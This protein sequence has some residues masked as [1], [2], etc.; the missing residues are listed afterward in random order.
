MCRIWFKYGSQAK[1][2]SHQ[3]E[4]EIWNEGESGCLGKT[5][6]E[7]LTTGPRVVTEAIKAV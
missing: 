4:S 5:I 3:T 7:K 1:R 2:R 6:K